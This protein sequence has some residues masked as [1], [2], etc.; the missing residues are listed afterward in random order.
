MRAEG[1]EFGL[2]HSPG[3]EDTDTPVF[4]LVHGIGT[5]H[6]YFAFLQRALATSGATYSVDLPGFGGMERPRGGLAI[7]AYATLLGCV[8]GTLLGSVRGRRC[9]VIGHSMGAQIATEL[10]AQYP[11][12]VSHLVLIGPVIDSRRCS[13]IAQAI[14]LGRDTLKEPP[15]ANLLVFGDYARCGPRWYTQELLSMLSYAISA[16]ISHVS[17]PT[18]VIRGSRDPVSRHAWCAGLVRRARRGAL[19][20]VVGHRHLVQFT[21]PDDVAGR[22]RRFAQT[23]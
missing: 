1:F 20:E 11:E 13:A 9:V 19:E 14:D 8:L 4:F 2:T 12:L 16:R 7:A 21:A 5:S 3:P 22:I 23:A 10:A 15:A 6:R 18:L 17:A